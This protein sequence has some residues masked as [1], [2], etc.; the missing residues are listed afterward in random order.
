M[1]ACWPWQDAAR[2]GIPLKT[3]ATVQQVFCAGSTLGCFAGTGVWGCSWLPQWWVMY[4]ALLWVSTLPHPK[5]CTTPADSALRYLQVLSRHPISLPP[6]VAGAHAAA[7]VH[8]CMYSD[9]RACHKTINKNIDGLYLQVLGR[10]AVSLSLSAAGFHAAADGD[11][12]S[13]QLP[14]LIS[15]AQRSLQESCRHHC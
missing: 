6:G 8:A 10:H 4:Q 7:A 1:C 9:Q 14:L 5:T 15:F 11:S 12:Q 3:S 2:T 13:L